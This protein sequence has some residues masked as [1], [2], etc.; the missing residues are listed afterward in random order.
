MK[1]F[2]DQKEGMIRCK[3]WGLGGDGTV[4]ANHNTVRIINE[5]TD[6]FSLAFVDKCCISCVIADSVKNIDNENQNQV[7]N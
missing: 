7:E 4:G 1:P 3:F 5:N 6:K 2:A